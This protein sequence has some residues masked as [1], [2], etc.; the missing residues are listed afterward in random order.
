MSRFETLDN[1]IIS[2]LSNQPTPVFDIW[3]K[4]RDEV[5]DINVIDRRM[6]HLKKK[7]LVANIRGKGWVK[8]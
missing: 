3:L 1:N 5:K 2:I 7:S 8:L 6:Q 4:F